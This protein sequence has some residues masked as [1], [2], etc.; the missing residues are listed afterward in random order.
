[1]EQILGIMLVSLG[2]LSAASFYVPS[3]KIKNW[4]WSTYW[5]SLGFVAWLIMPTIGGLL[6]TPDLAGI[7]RSSSV[8][9]MIWSYVFGAGWGFGGLMCGLGL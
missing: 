5:I 3:Y 7:I 1:M 2:G 4:S 9:G 6:T 8:G